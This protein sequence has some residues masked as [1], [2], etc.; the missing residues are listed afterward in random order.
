[1]ACVTFAAGALAGGVLTFGGLSALGHALGAGA[2]AVA[3]LVALAAAA[4]EARGAR[5]VPQVRRQVPESWRRVHARPARGRPVR[6]PARPRLHDVHPQLRRLGA[7]GDQRGARATRASASRS[8]SA[9]AWAARCPVVAMAPGGG[10]RAARRDGRAARASS[11]RCERS[12]PPRSP[13]APSRSTPRPRTRPSSSPPAPPTRASTVPPSRSTGPAATASCRGRRST[14]RSPAAIRRSAAA[15]RRGSP[16]TASWSTASARSP[17]PGANAVAVDADWVAWRANGALWAAA[18]ADLAPAP[19]RRRR[20]RPPRADRQPAAVRLRQG[21]ADLR[22]RPRRPA[23]ARRCGARATP[24]C[25]ASPP[26]RHGSPTSTP[27]TAASR[28]G[29]GRSRPAAPSK[30]RAVYG[31]VPTGRRD[32]GEEPGHHGAEGHKPQLWARPPPGVADTLTT[33]A[34]AADAVYVTRLRQRRHDGVQAAVLR[35]AR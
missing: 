22:L 3:A 7:R 27:P 19:D 8:A 17:R 14:S 1:M 18:L 2:P 16:A 20:P 24:R 15:G 29:S 23:C 6:R 5:I 30:D 33:T 25:A 13:P 12:T 11:G 35:F 34:L 21:H 28:C 26:R 10:G 32:A 9:S 4:G 31:T